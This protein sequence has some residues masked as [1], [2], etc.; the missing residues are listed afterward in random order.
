[1]PRRVPDWPALPRLV[2]IFRP[3]SGWPT[4]PRRSCRTAPCLIR[5]WPQ[6]ARSAPRC[7]YRRNITGSICPES[8]RSSVLGATPRSDWPTF[9][10]PSRSLECY[11]GLRATRTFVVYITTANGLGPVLTLLKD[12]Y[13]SIAVKYQ[14]VNPGVVRRIVDGPPLFKLGDIARA[15][16]TRQTPFSSPTPKTQA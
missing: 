13:S 2:G 3:G 16:P 7:F 11:R 14:I 4:L 1:M 12:V 6:R 5:P 10:H 9:H 15:A 8:L